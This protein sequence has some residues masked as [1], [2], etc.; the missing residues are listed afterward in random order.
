MAEP[1]AVRLISKQKVKQK[2]VKKWQQKH[3]WKKIIVCVLWK[4]II[5]TPQKIF[6]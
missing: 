1:G 5:K 2:Q 6:F 3:V 4:I